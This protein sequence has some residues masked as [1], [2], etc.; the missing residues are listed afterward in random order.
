MIARDS[1]RVLIAY[2]I[3]DDKRRTRIAKTLLSYGDRLQYSVFLFD[4][5]PVDLVRLRSK[6]EMMLLPDLDYVAICDLGPS[7]LAEGTVI[8]YLGLEPALTDQDSFIL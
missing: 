3:P 8:T 4:I 6:L 2:D 7:A 1:R 5:R